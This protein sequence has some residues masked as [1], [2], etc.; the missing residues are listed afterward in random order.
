[1]NTTTNKRTLQKQQR[2]DDIIQAAKILFLERGIHHVQLQEVAVAANIGIATLYRYFPNKEQLVFA[3]N[4]IITVQMVE[5]IEAIDA[6]PINAYEKI[7]QVFNY[8]V[9]M[10]DETEQPFMQFIKAFERYKTYG[11]Q[12]D[13]IRAYYDIRRTMADVLLRIV[14]RGRHDGS[15]RTDIDLNVYIITT[16]QNISTF[17][18]ESTFT[19]HD[20]RLPVHLMPKEQLTLVRDMFLQYV[21][22]SS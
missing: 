21:R 19:Q 11:E 16:V 2:R 18:T 4:N 10:T 20:P 5:H 7:E 22:A 14:A 1:M 12:T 17:M 6:Q 3:V 13:E 8:Y 9:Q 15:L